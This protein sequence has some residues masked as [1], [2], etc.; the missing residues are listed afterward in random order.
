ML[1]VQNDMDPNS[2]NV[3]VVDKFLDASLDAKLILDEIGLTEEVESI[4]IKVLGPILGRFL[5]PQVATN[6][7]EE[8]DVRLYWLW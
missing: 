7:K 4:P 6:S 2:R 8:T 5:H 1:T 3:E